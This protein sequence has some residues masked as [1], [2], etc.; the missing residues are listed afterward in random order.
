M[1]GIDPQVNKTTNS[2][3]ANHK[4]LTNDVFNTSEKNKNIIYRG[5]NQELNQPQETINNNMFLFG[6]TGGL[7]ECLSDLHN[8]IVSNEY[9]ELGYFV[10]QVQK[11]LNYDLGEFERTNHSQE[12]DDGIFDD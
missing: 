6:C 2:D 8:Q 7:P 10:E 1:T 3:D 5:K 4:I 9:H 12:K 11:N